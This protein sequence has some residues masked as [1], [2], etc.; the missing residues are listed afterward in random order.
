MS[1]PLNEMAEKDIDYAIGFIIPSMFDLDMA[2]DIILERYLWMRS[3][4]PFYQFVKSNTAFLFRCND[5]W[6]LIEWGTFRILFIGTCHDGIP[7]TNH[8]VLETQIIELK[9]QLTTL[10]KRVALLN[11]ANSYIKHMHIV[12]D[13]LGFNFMDEV[14]SMNHQ[15]NDEYA[16]STCN[17]NK[18][19]KQLELVAEEL[20][21]EYKSYSFMNQTINIERQQK[22]LTV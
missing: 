17:I 8:I 18:L 14:N 4:D 13:K 5:T 22:Y 16:T 1:I 9:L 12:T 7:Q 3:D 11:E 20:A 6:I 21:I 19:Q 2:A 15:L 10:E